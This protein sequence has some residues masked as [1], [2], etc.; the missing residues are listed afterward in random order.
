ML[1]GKLRMKFGGKQFHMAHDPNSCPVVTRA[2]VS[3]RG[4]MSQ[5]MTLTLL[6]S[7]LSNPFPLPFMCD[8]A[9]PFGHAFYSPLA[10]SAV[11]S[12]MG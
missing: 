11:E 5:E 7:E 3:L 10:I 12:N 8:S 6:E 1:T 4:L 2:G 9:V